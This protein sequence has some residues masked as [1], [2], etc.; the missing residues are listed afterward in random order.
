MMY[1]RIT[2]AGHRDLDKIKVLYENTFPL[3]E[4]RTWQSMT[5]LLTEPAMHLN[6]IKAEAQFIGFVI[7]WHLQEWLYVEHFSI[8]PQMRK[9]QYG[10][11]VV[12]DLKTIGNHQ[13]VLETELPENEESKRRIGFYEKCGL[14]LLPFPYHQPPYR[15]GEPASPMLLMSTATASRRRYAEVVNLLQHE[16]YEKFY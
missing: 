2:Y 14:M 16:V 11:Q 13:L 8:I 5:L 12:E 6:S 9:K 3:H 4:R 7:Y 1:E 15:K 10:S